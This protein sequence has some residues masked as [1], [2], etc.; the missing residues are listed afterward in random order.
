MYSTSWLGLKSRERHTLSGDILIPTF[1]LSRLADLL[2]RVRQ[3]H[4]QFADVHEDVAAVVLLGQAHQCAVGSRREAKLDDVDFR[5]PAIQAPQ[6]PQLR[7][8]RIVLGFAV[9]Q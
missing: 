1:T 8:G 5:P 9:G 7:L 4:G 2:R 3:A 6:A